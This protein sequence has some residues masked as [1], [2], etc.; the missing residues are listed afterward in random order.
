MLAHRHEPPGS[1]NGSPG[2]GSE[3]AWDIPSFGYV[4]ALDGVRAFA[5]LA[6]VALHG[7]THL[8]GGFIGVD[9]FFV[10]SG[11]LITTL[12][13]QE[14]RA[15][16]DFRLRAFYVRR[17]RRLLP[18]LALTLVGVTV[19]VA[20]FAW[21]YDGGVRYGFA[22]LSVIFYAGNWVAAFTVHQG[23]LGP[24]THTWSLAIE[25]Q[26]Y[27]LWPLLLLFFFGRVSVLAA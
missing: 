26:F 1:P 9:V 19:L 14:W 2:G 4:P 23:A 5:V 13:L 25:E 10:L 21:Y 3:Q 18:A 17:A 16:G 7:G 12:L 20:A 22:V 24:L 27:L 11:F 8:N 6:V 15:R